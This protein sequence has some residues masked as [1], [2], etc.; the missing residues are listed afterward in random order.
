MIPCLVTL[1]ALQAHHAG[2]AALAE[3]N[4]FHFTLWKPLFCVV[5][6]YI[7]KGA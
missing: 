3:L 5:Q 6:I 1:T 2:L 7:E 4:V